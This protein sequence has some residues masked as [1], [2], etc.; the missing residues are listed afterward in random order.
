[1]DYDQTEMPE[2]YD[3]G[4][5]PPDGVL[6]MWMDRIEAGVIRPVSSIIDLGCGTGRF[7]ELLAKRFNAATIGIDPSSK[8]LTQARAKPPSA[9]VTYLQ[10]AGE[11]LPCADQSADLIFSSMAFHHFK[12]PPLVARECHRVLRKTGVV[13]IRNSTRGHGSPYEAFFPNYSQTLVALPA[14]TEIIDAFT[15][16]GFDLSSHE[17]VAHKMAESVADLAEKA[18]FRADSTLIRLSNEDFERGI[19]SMRAVA[20]TRKEPAM[21]DI[22]LFVFT[23]C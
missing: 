19:A 22:D 4:R 23:R 16:N 13:C 15:H 9:R 17:T 14:A 5:T 21:I 6:D 11:Q 7:T 2:T 8:M 18:S 1:M 3:R 10:G 12:S 20:S